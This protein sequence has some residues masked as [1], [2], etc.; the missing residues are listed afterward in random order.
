MLVFFSLNL[1]QIDDDFLQDYGIHIDHL[2][3]DCFHI[4]AY[5]WNVFLS[6]CV[7]LVEL[8]ALI[9]AIK[10]RKIKIKILNDSREIS[11]IVYVTTI[12]TVEASVVAI[13]LQG[14]DTLSESLLSTAFF[15]ITSTI[16][17][18]VHIPKVDWE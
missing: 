4:A 15:I 16:L 7:V 5:S 11:I 3:V 13:I 18:L 8:A 6:S 12:A 2:Q 10:T 17:G 1:L 14:F 9:L